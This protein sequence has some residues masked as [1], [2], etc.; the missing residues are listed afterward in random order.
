[1]FKPNVENEVINNVDAVSSGLLRQMLSVQKIADCVAEFVQEWGVLHEIAFNIGDDFELSPDVL[2]LLYSNQE[3]QCN[4]A[5]TLDITAANMARLHSTHSAFVHCLHLEYDVPW[6]EERG[7]LRL[8]FTSQMKS[9]VLQELYWML[10]DP[11]RFRRR[12]SRNDAAYSLLRALLIAC[13][14]QLGGPV[15]E[16]VEHTK[17]VREDVEHLTVTSCMFTKPFSFTLKNQASLQFERHSQSFALTPG[18]TNSIRNYNVFSPR[19]QAAL[20]PSEDETP[21][22]PLMLDTNTLPSMNAGDMGH[23]ESLV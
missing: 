4:W 12:Y 1:M 3:E 7:I 6:N 11:E 8:N 16:L 23:R 13:A 20:S 18:L 21:H 5:D 15:M 22:L 17:N 9:G 19:A 14:G 10:E 2:K